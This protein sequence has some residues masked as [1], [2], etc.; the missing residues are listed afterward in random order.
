MTVRLR[1]ELLGLTLL[2]ALPLAAQPGPVNAP[3]NAVR[4]RFASVPRGAS[5]PPASSLSGIPQ[6]QPF[7]VGLGLSAGFATGLPGGTPA[8]RPGRGFHH[9]GFGHRAIR[10]HFFP[11]FF[12]A[13][14]V[15][16]STLLVVPQPVWVEVPVSAPPGS[17]QPSPPAPP[18]GPRIESSPY[19][20]ADGRSSSWDAS[21]LGIR[22]EEVGGELATQFGV[23]NGQ[24]ILIREVVPG[25]PAEKAGLQA[26]D[27]I[28][29]VDG[30]PVRT[31][32]ELWA[33]FKGSLDPENI[34]LGLLRR[35]V[36]ISVL[37]QVD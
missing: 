12:F 31:L 29:S 5:L 21:S 25:S 7:P 27:I 14:Q 17:G 1:A 3:P 33:R 6:L 4:V 37:L 34:P 23:P 20:R 11:T 16:S 19:F 2:V 9:P 24:G 22:G 15:G 36:Q 8:F 30:K 35:G 13:D 28:V 10:P 32:D 26:G 18:S